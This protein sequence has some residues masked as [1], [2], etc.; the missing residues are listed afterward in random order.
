MSA[1]AAATHAEAIAD[2]RAWPLLPPPL[3]ALGTDVPR[4]QQ[5]VVLRMMH[6]E[7]VITAI[8]NVEHAP[9]SRLSWAAAQLEREWVAYAL[10]EQSEHQDAPPARRSWLA[11]LTR[12][13]VTHQAPAHQEDPQ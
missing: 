5:R 8:Q 3:P 12:R 1:A 7:R 6:R 9:A 11:R 10:F 13:P 4:A 2:G